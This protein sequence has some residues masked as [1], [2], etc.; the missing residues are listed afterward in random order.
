MTGEKLDKL[1]ALCAAGAAG[2]GKV[3]VDAGELL[4]LVSELRELQKHTFALSALAGSVDSLHRLLG[5]LSAH[6]DL[7]LGSSGAHPIAVQDPG[8]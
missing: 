7:D 5:T 6:H 8:R 4:E 2:N 1:A 3:S